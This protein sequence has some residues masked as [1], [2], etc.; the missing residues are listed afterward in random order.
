MAPKKILFL[1]IGCVSLALGAVGAFLPILPCV[2][3][4]LIAA[5][6]FAHSSDQLDRWFKSTKLYQNHLA[7]YTRGEGMTKN[8]K[9]RVI[10]TVTL[11]MGLGFFMMARVPVGRIILVSVWVLHVLY[12]VFG[13]KTKPAT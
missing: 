5:W 7:S 6:A 8:T 9:L 4:L 13:V 3:F 10:A 2:P 11:V 1:I 12:F